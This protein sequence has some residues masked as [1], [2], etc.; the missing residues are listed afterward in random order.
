VKRI[1]SI[2]SVFLVLFFI[3]AFVNPVF[4]DATF[5]FSGVLRNGSGTPITNVNV[6]LANETNHDSQTTDGNGSFSLRVP[7]GTYDLVVVP[8]GVNT[9]IAPGGLGAAALGIVVNSDVEQDLVL[10]TKTLAVAVLDTLGQPVANA[11][12]SIRALPGNILPFS[13]FSGANAIVSTPMTSNASTNSSGVAF[14]AL[15]PSSS[16]EVFIT[17]P[18]SSNLSGITTATPFFDDTSKTIILPAVFSYSGVLRNGAGTAIPNIYLTLGNGLASNF[19]Q[20]DVDGSFSLHIPDSAVFGQYTLTIPTVGNVDPSVA[21]QA[22]NAITTGITVNSDTMQ[23]LTLPTKVL[24]I[25]ILG[26]SGQP[27]PGAQVHIQSQDYEIFP[28]SLFPGAPNTVVYTPMISNLVTNTSGIA[29]F[30]WLLSSSVAITIFPP[31]ESGLQQKQETILFLDTTDVTISYHQNQPPTIDAG[32]PYQVNEGNSVQVAAIGNDPENGPLTYAWDLDNNG[33]FE[34]PGQTITFS[35]AGLDGPSS[36]TITV[37]VTDDGGLTASAQAIVNV[38]NVVPVVGAITAPV[39]PNQVNTSINTS[40][41]FT[42]VGIPDTHTA[43]WDWGDATTSVGT[44]TETNGSGSVIG[45]HAYTTP[46]VYTIK[47]TVVDDDGGSGESV[48]QFVVVYDPEEGFVTGGGWIDS[49]S[50]AY[51]ANPLLT[52][53]AN[54]GFVSKYQNGATVPTG[55]TEFHFKVASFNLHSTSYDWLVVAGP[56]AKYKGSGT[57]NGSGNYGFMLTAVDGQVNGGGNIDRFR[58]KIWDKNTNEVIYDNQMGESD[59][60]N[61]TDAI[62][63]GSIVIHQ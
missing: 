31:T 16:L 32:G 18:P 55:Q 5:G 45:S 24:T 53:R 7:S 46:G 20:T 29:R 59:D 13:F 36:R 12:V 19:N 54:F 48:F 49:P 51:T 23:D 37:Q 6:I 9:S 30:A 15:L 62:E 34:T 41:N 40:A 52:G 57:I 27:L 21:P 47:L 25:T 22:M 26:A 42:D 3:L 17:P 43:V 63:A 28:F 61:A 39:D 38:V 1:I 58:I 60:T 4:A 50:G 14:L 33:S 10:P 35:A 11:S 8:V 56:N 44:V 2:A